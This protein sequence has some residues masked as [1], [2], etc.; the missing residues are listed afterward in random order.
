MLQRHAKM[1]AEQPSGVK[2]LVAQVV[3]PP[4]AGTSANVAL[5][6]SSALPTLG[7]SHTLLKLRQRFEWQPE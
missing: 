4:R 7:V 6:P 5:L 1:P 2:R 3:A